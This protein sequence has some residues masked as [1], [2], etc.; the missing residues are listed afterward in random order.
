[1]EDDRNN[2]Q[3]SFGSNLNNAPQLSFAHIPPENVPVDSANN[4]VSAAISFTMLN[5]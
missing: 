2:C 1:M 5:S 4:P 3:V